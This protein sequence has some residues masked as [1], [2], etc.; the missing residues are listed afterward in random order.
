MATRIN[1]YQ[2]EPGSEDQILRVSSGVVTWVDLTDVSGVASADMI[3]EEVPSG[4]INGSNALFTLSSAAVS[5]NHIRLYIDGLRQDQGN[6]YTVAGAS[7]LTISSTAP[8]T[9]QLLFVDYTRA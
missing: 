1:A 8:E 7:A 9:G 4:A 6:D 3:F 2:I 5:D